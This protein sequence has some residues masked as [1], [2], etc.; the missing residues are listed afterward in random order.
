MLRSSPP[1]I[2]PGKKLACFSV[3]DPCTTVDFVAAFRKG[4]YIP[5]HAK[6]YIKIV[7]DFT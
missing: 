6:E 7:K 5:Y 4:S 3:G 1:N 2:S